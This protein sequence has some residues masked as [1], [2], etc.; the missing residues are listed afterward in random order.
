MARYKKSDF[1]PAR[2]W[3]DA[4]PEERRARIYEGARKTIREV[5]LREIREA[6]GKTQK[7]VAAT[8]DVAQPEVS[9]IEKA[10]DVHVSTL[11]KHI[12]AL[13]GDLDLV[14]FFP[15]GTA[16]LIDLQGA[17]PVKSTIKPMEETVEGLP[18]PTM[19]EGKRSKRRSA[20]TS[21]AAA[22]VRA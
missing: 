13:G 8:L 7:E 18:V 22:R 1:R 19:D 6:V 14:A 20:R 10:S 16:M 15:D 17:R 4:L 2:E 3:I 12:K 21:K 5:R 9:R 11:Q